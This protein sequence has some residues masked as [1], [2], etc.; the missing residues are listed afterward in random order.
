M[1]N[2]AHSTYRF[3][4][5]FA[6]RNVKN[7]NETPSDGAAAAR[8]R[9]NEIAVAA[10]FAGFRRPRSPFERLA[11]RRSDDITRRIYSRF[12]IFNSTPNGTAELFARRIDRRAAEHGRARTRVQ[13]GAP[14]RA[15][16]P[17]DG[18]DRSITKRPTSFFRIFA[19]KT[20]AQ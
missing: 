15:Y 12:F 13:A 18:H 4:S 10:A 14:V 11:R 9:E 19:I 5:F 20:I 17:R 6:V 3:G 16:K 1:K 7:E 2:N 8:G